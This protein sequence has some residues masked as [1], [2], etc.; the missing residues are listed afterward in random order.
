MEKKK[1]RKIFLAVLLI[2][3]IF[4]CA[5]IVS[6]SG[7]NVFTG[8]VSLSNLFLTFTSIGKLF[9]NIEKPGFILIESP[10]NITYYFNNSVNVYTLDL[11]VSSNK[12][13]SWTY[14]L[15]D[16]RHNVI[17]VNNSIFVPNITID[18]NRWSNLLVV[19][20]IENSGEVLSSNVTFFVDVPAHSPIISNLS[21]QIYAC[22]GSPLDLQFYADDADEN[23]MHGSISP[24][25]VADQIY[26]V[27]S[28]VFNISR[29]YFRI[30]S[31][32]MTKTNAG[33]VNAG[34]KNYSRQV[35]V[36]DSVKSDY[37]NINITV[38]ETNHFPDIGPISVQTVWTSGNE[39]GFYYQVNATDYEDGNSDS[40]KLNFSISFSGG[41]QLFNI[42]KKGIMNYTPSALDI[43]SYDVTVCMSDRGLSKPH[44]NITLCGQ[45]GRPV[46]TCEIFYLTVTNT[47]RRPK[48]LSH[49]PDPLSFEARDDEALY[50]NITKYD[51]DGPALDTSWYVDSENKKNDTANV[52]NPFS[53]FTYTFPCGVSGIHR[54]LTVISDGNL[55]D[56]LL[57]N[58]SVIFRDCAAPAPNT[59]SSPSSP[60]SKLFCNETWGCRDWSNC[61]N[62]KVA[63][64]SGMI[65]NIDKKNI[66]GR[67]KLFSW[68]NSFCGYQTRSCIDLSACN[69]SRSLPG[70]IRECYF[71]KNPTCNDGIKNCH[72]GSCE[73][74]ADCGGP[75][76]PCA[77]CSDST[78]NQGEEG[79][80]CGG[81]CNPCKKE[82]PIIKTSETPLRYIL[83]ILFFALILFMIVV[84]IINLIRY[85][86]M[87]HRL[88]EL[89]GSPFRY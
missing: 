78:Q 66:L 26:L 15:Y 76:G 12:N 57:W 89:P 29:R 40:G 8:F 77:T 11:N 27:D 71:T 47:N 61:I 54:V 1:K 63:G 58:V 82:T 46:N 52:L 16:L 81:P 2:A 49:Y 19:N 17:L 84:T 25:I 70:T 51:P 23:T 6:R 44:P 73:V 7:N 36:D 85:L 80:D 59:I 21:N 31:G 42:S 32:V 64:E 22:E 9:I 55:T 62:L 69:T 28:D 88:E 72:D 3:I 10:Q 86:D 33:G 67:C 74:L 37:K 14:S 38:I 35:S 5:F 39:S 75:C 79:V 18:V 83:I 87:K 45:D 41:R 13:L 34:C 30:Y 24:V 4:S 50:F 53:D 65:G 20:G 43:G 48:I 60:I 56:S 68:D